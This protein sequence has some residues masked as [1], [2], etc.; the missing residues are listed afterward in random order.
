MIL[1]PFDRS[2]SR[3][4]HVRIILQPSEHVHGQVM[5]D[6]H[7]AGEPQV[8]RPVFEAS[9]PFC[10]RLGHRAGIAIDNLD[11]AGRASRIAPAPMQNID[12]AVFDRQHETSAV[13]CLD[14]RVRFDYNSMYAVLL[15]CF[16]TLSLITVAGI[17][18]VHFAC[19]GRH[20]QI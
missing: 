4:G 18:P 5:V 19:A 9:Q 7:L 11:T 2:R 6:L 3:I 8:V 14:D 13:T 17:V 12:S 10:L 1:R 16:Q 20:Q 15:P